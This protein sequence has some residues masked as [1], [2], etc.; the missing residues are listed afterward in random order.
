LRL[1]SENGNRGA[2]SD[3]FGISVKTFSYATHS[4][5]RRSN[6]ARLPWKISA[7][8]IDV[9]RGLATITVTPEPP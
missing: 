2:A 5:A 8:H 4:M 3:A 1:D 9:A 7:I 6:G